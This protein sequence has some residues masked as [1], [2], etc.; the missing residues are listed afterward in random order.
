MANDRM[1]YL[2]YDATLD[3]WLPC[4]D[5]SRFRLL[6][7]FNLVR[8]E[9]RREA[10]WA[11]APVQALADVLGLHRRQTGEALKELVARG[12]LERD[13]TYPAHPGRRPALFIPNFWYPDWRVPLRQPREVVLRSM[14]FR[15]GTDGW[16]V[17]RSV[18]ARQTGFVARSV[19]ARQIGAEEGLSRG[20][21]GARQMSPRRAVQDR[22][23][24]DGRRAVIGARLSDRARGAHLSSVV[25]EGTNSLES[26][27][28]EGF[29]HL[30]RLVVD[31]AADN[32]DGRA[33][34]VYGEPEAILLDL[35]C[36]CPID[37][38]RA[39]LEYR[40]KELGVPKLVGWLAEQAALDF[41]ALPS[42]EALERAAAE[43]ERR[44]AAF[45]AGGHDELAA[46]HTELAEDLRSRI[47]PIR[48]TDPMEVVS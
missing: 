9:C 13:P 41:I 45:A 1:L 12:L 46:H 20:L 33:K 16:F 47:T 30:K 6:H 28:A 32:P 48:D 5:T 29:A 37:K 19:S 42:T 4:I 8:A 14:G 17:A 21:L 23:T 36:R 24:N 11:P 15:R 18:S 39:V 43:H 22:A 25:P 26:E 3:E 40:P 35:A 10:G 34:D 44:A 38:L 7:H 31:A 27:Q 2:E